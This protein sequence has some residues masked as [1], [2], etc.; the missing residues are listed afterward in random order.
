LIQSNSEYWGRS[1][2]EGQLG[3]KGGVFFFFL[4]LIKGGVGKEE[5]Q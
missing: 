2:E 5:E 1:R 3:A 4:K